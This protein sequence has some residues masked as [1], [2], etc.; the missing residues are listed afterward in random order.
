MSAELQRIAAPAEVRPTKPPKS[1]TF[2]VIILLA[3]LCLTTVAVL[4]AAF[5]APFGADEA[6]NLQIPQ[7]LV[8]GGGYSTDLSV[9]LRPAKSTAFDPN[10]STGPTL[11]LPV[12]LLAKI[13]GTAAWTYRLVPMG[14]YLALVA[15]GVLVGRRV[16]HTL[17]GA[18]AGLAVV[19]ASPAA[20][21]WPNSP[22]FGAG[23]VLGEFTMG[24]LIT[25]AALMLRRPRIAGAL[26]GLA[27]M[28]KFLA[29]IV[30]P[31]FAV[32]LTLDRL[33]HATASRWRVRARFRPQALGSLAEFGVWAMAPVLLW[34]GVKISTVGL[35]QTG[36]IAQAFLTLFL[37]AGSGLGSGFTSNNGPLG[38]L[39]LLA[40]LFPLTA[41]VLFGVAV[42]ATVIA[43]RREHTTRPDPITE[44]TWRGGWALA[45]SGGA[46]LIWWV[47]ISSAAYVRH[48]VP[49]VVVLLPLASV[50]LL[51]DLSRPNAAGVMN[52]VRRT[53]ATCLVLGVAVGAASHAWA[54]WHPPGPSPAEQRQFAT[55]LASIDADR[56]IA[57]R[58]VPALELGV[59]QDFRYVPLQEGRILVVGP[60][61]ERLDP[62]EAARQRGLC[63]D[64]LLKTKNYL[65]CRLG[66]VPG[67][68]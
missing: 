13:L 19:A 51:R 52:V 3:V 37:H 67:Q 59:F 53:G 14:A 4:A 31:A 28:T 15:C 44:S 68:S 38:Q 9:W 24:A 65:A 16:H 39:S 55:Q 10:I 30:V 20:A 23:D 50:W 46:I 18:V 60:V 62:Q 42:G 21:S 58:E 47:F 64:V 36:R 29:V 45:L 41:I 63:A 49:G 26:V 32:A 2:L 33:P 66:A 35:A 61:L 48:A 43:R 5:R 27:I 6:Y 57:W 11:L 7:N 56:T 22:L 25:G 8:R 34:Q 17:G 54:A 40:R 12:A 1:T